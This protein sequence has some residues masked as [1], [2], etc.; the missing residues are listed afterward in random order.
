M[1]SLRYRQARG[2]DGYAKP[3]AILLIM[4]CTALSV[5]MLGVITAQLTPTLFAAKNSRTIAAAEAG[6]DAS[7]TVIRSARSIDP[8]SSTE[9]GDPR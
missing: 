3:T 1:D 6:V 4:V 8:I 7:L 5:L 9:L 2:D